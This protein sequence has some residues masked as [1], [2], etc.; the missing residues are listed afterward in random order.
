M[1]PEA[2]MATRAAG[3]QIQQEKYS[4][5]DHIN[6]APNVTT[7]AANLAFVRDG[8]TIPLDQI[9]RKIVTDTYVFV[10]KNN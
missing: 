9:H 8:L 1:G 7:E 2:P 6:K 4:T 10:F 5:A 3:K